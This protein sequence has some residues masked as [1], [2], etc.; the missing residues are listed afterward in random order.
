MITWSIEPTAGR[1]NTI[2][3]KLCPTK[4]LKLG[5]LETRFKYIMLNQIRSRSTSSLKT[6][7]QKEN[8]H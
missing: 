5:T 7:T 8:T 2:L 6:H 1:D 4:Y 3:K